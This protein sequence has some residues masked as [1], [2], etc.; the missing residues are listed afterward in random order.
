MFFLV[1]INDFYDNKYLRGFLKNLK[2][3]ELLTILLIEHSNP[4]HIDK[5]PKELI[6]N[7]YL[8]IIKKIYKTKLNNYIL[9]II[10]DENDTAQAILAQ[11]ILEI[12]SN[13]LF[14]CLY[15]ITSSK[16]LKLY[17]NKENNLK[18]SNHKAIILLLYI[19]DFWHFYYFYL[20]N[21]INLLPPILL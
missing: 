12:S 3:K 15:S 21:T 19:F 14:I 17:F 8:N 6:N 20:Y 13:F 5:V 9:I 10:I 4:K 16:L 7:N 2:T 18:T 1:L 11:N